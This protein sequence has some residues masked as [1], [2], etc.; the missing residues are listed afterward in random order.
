MPENK[1]KEKSINNIN[2]TLRAVSQGSIEATIQSGGYG[3][4]RLVGMDCK[5]H[6]YLKLL[7][8]KNLCS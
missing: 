2:F 6:I 5:N 4:S 7:N 1:H 8:L 3:L